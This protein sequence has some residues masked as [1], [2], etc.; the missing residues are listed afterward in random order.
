MKALILLGICSIAFAGCHKT[1]PKTL[2]ITQVDTCAEV[3][4]LATFG[5]KEYK[6]STVNHPM[7]IACYSPIGSENVGKD[8][9]ATLD[10]LKGVFNVRLDTGIEPY[11]IRAVRDVK[12]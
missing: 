7:A 5:D 11:A 10:E 2:H 9:P 6:L 3:S 12:Q 1:A 8:L 4:V